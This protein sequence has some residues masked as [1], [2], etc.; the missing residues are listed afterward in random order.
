M[1]RSGIRERLSG[2]NTDPGF[3]CHSI[4]ATLAAAN[5]NGLGMLT[6]YFDDSGTHDDSEIVILAGLFGNERA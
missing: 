6:T 4:R 5:P 1:E 3:C 2:S